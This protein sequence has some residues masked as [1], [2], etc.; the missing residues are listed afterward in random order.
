M[1]AERALKLL[2]AFQKVFP[3]GQP[4]TLYYQGWYEWLT[5]KPQAA[6]HTWNK[7]LESAKKF[8]MPYQEGLIRVKLGIALQH[9]LTKRQHLERAIQIFEQMGAV[10]EL[11]VAQ[12]ASKKVGF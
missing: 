3:I 2:R 7:G 11:T 10:H 4:V 5:D 12:E 9:D 1:L 8:N 6:I